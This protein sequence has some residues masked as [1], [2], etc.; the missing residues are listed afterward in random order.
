[1]GR[2]EQVG[3]PLRWAIGLAVPCLEL[4]SVIRW[5]DLSLPWCRIVARSPS[6][7]ARWPSSSSRSLG[8]ASHG[9]P[10]APFPATLSLAPTWSCLAGVIPSVEGL[11][12]RLTRSTRPRDRPGRG[13]SFS[14]EPGQVGRAA[15]PHASPAIQRPGWLSPTSCPP[16]L[17]GV[18]VMDAAA[19]AATADQGWGA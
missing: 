19:A 15:P 18:A 7:T 3:G 5:R 11:E 4:G 14:L 17:L 12:P 10:H 2:K 8:R 6:R 1:M 9:G 16:P 13:L